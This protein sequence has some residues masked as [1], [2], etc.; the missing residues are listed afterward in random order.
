MDAD[1]FVT[2]LVSAAEAEDTTIFE[3]LDR[4]IEAYIAENRYH[5][6]SISDLLNDLIDR[7]R[8]KAS[9]LTNAVWDGLFKKLEARRG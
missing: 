5:Y 1:Q 9:H 3:R 8:R 6:A 7:Y 4:E 2:H